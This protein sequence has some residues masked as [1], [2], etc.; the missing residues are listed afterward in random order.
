MIFY[1]SGTGNS[2]W[3]ANQIAT[4][5][6]E[7]LVDIGKAFV[8]G[9]FE[10]TL[11]DGERVGFVFPVHS[12]GPA[13]IVVEFAKRLH[14]ENFNR[15][16]KFVYAIAVCGDDIGLTMDILE[17]ALPQDMML[18]SKFSVQMPN[19]YI[20]LPGFDTDSKTLELT[21]LMQAR[22]R[23]Y[24]ISEAIAERRCREEIVRGAFPALKS[25]LIY[26]VY[27]RYAMSDHSFTVTKDLCNMCN[28]CAHKCPVNNI[29][30]TS[31]GPK[32]HGK[33]E[34]CL[35]CIHHCPKRAIEYGKISRKKGR[36]HHPESR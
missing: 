16:S 7:S 5:L 8:N 23:V 24:E 32:W 13:P 22:G 30:M 20:L 21:K 29:I 26:P 2:R 12:W 4:T 36:Y 19:N 14:L 1:F 27:K 6:G 17:S 3:L 34:M 10:Y 28:I 9:I 35:A 11:K 18:N 31:A 25:R 15:E 33:C